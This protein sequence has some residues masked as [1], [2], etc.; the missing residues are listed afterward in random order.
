MLVLFLMCVAT[1]QI[2]VLLADET[3]IHLVTL[4]LFLKVLD[5][6]LVVFGTE[7]AIANIDHESCILLHV[8]LSHD[9]VLFVGLKLL[10]QFHF[11]S[12]KFN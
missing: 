1:A 7:I 10:F 12:I 11:F 5:C 4:Y 3:F 6:L 2:V 9:G 8:F